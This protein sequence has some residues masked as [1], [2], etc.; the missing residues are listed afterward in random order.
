MRKI[1]NIF[2]HELMDILK[3]EGIW[4]DSKHILS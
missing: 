3:D 2:Y 4:K 1:R